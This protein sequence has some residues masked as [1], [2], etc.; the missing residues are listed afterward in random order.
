MK[1][2]YNVCSVLRVSDYRV[3]YSEVGFEF[4]PIVQNMYT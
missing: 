1:L 2:H 3:F 4:Y